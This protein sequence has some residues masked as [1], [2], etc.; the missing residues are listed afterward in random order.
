MNAFVHF[1]WLVVCCTEVSKEGSSHL[2]PGASF[3]EDTGASTFVHAFLY[4]C[5]PSV[6][7]LSRQAVMSASSGSDPAAPVHPSV[8]SRVVMLAMYVHESQSVCVHCSDPTQDA[9]AALALLS[10][11]ACC[12]FFSSFCAGQT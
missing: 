1:N 11:F 10:L 6:P 8:F 9:L 3:L 4:F 5:L 12:W 7:S 2:I